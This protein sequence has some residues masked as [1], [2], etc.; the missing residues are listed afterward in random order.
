MSFC[1]VLE[2]VDI[3][4]TSLRSQV[5][6]LLFL[7]EAQAPNDNKRSLKNLLEQKQ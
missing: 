5:C 2:D 4:I 6:I 3:S 1:L 7:E